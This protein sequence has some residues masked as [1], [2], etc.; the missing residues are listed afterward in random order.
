[1]YLDFSKYISPILT[2]VSIK[3]QL[4]QLVQTLRVP[5]VRR[6]Q[7]LQLR[8]GHRSQGVTHAENQSKICLSLLWTDLPLLL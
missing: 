1:M 4:Q 2:L 3:A 8:L 7:E 5:R 6:H